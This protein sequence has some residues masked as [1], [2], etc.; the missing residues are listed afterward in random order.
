M[1]DST[2]EA[3]K[4]L[5]P[6]VGGEKAS[7]NAFLAAVGVGSVLGW[8]ITYAVVLTTLPP[9]SGPVSP[10]TGAW[11]VTAAW[12]VLTVLGVGIASVRVEPGVLFS[13]PVLAWVGLVAVG[14]VASGYGTAVG[15][16]AL[17]WGAW[18]GVLAVGYLLTGALVTRGGLYVVSG[19]LVVVATGV[20]FFALAQADRPHSLVLGVL[21]VV[22]V[23]VDAARG[24]RQLND[25]GVPV[26]KAE[27]TEDR[28]GGVIEAD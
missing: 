11:L 28:A 14:F 13:T 19:V 1:S 18:Y 17:M 23:V 12:L 21:G 20:V 10:K 7:A 2:F 25:D 24:G 3:A 26:V 15:N 4:R 22:P 9:G 8:A 5:V 27:R 6:G 16:V